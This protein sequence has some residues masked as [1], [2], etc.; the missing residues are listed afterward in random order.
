MKKLYKV[1]KVSAEEI[2]EDLKEEK[3]ESKWIT[4][5]TVTKDTP[6][7]E[8]SKIISKAIEMARKLGGK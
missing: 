4:V 8:V 6:R 2:I 1:D 7:E 3:E 5:A